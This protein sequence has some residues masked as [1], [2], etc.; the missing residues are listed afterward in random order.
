MGQE[1]WPTQQTPLAP[2]VIDLQTKALELARSARSLH[3]VMGAALRPGP[4][5]H[6]GR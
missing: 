6:L 2:H 1:T 4:P 5:P 3:G